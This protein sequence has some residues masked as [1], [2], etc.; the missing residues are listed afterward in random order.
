METHVPH[1]RLRVFALVLSL[2][3]TLVG[4]G[5]GTRI[6]AVCRDG[7]QSSS[8]GSGTCS[9]HGGVEYWIYAED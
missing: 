7:W 5:G 3:L 8:T 6:G 9:H 4:C 1:T 2:A